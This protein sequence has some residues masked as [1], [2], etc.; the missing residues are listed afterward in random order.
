L[1]A[2]SS[3]STARVGAGDDQEVLVSPGLHGGLELAQHRFRLDQRF[4]V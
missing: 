2:P 4:V 1:I 3:P